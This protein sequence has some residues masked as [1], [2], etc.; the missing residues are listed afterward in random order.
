VHENCLLLVAIQPL[1]FRKGTDSI[2]AYCKY[3]L[4][5]DPYNGVLYAFRNKAGRAVKILAFD[6][7]GV[8]LVIRRF[9]QGKLAWWPQSIDQAL[10][11]LAAQQLAVLLAQG[12]PRHAA[13]PEDWCKIG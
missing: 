2:A 12:N 11:P 8:Y 1:D 4:D 3:Q 9:S 7:V 10:Q 13:F 5:Q 6:G